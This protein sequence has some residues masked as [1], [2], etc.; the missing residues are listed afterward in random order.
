MFQFRLNGA[1][2]IQISRQ[3]AG[4]LNAIEL[5]AEASLSVP[6]F[7][8][9]AGIFHYRSAK[10]VP[11]TNFK[12]GYNLQQRLQYFRLASLNGGY[13]YLWRESTQ[14]THEYYPVDVSFVKLSTTSVT[15][16]SLLAKSPVL[17]NSFQNQ[18]I[19]GSHY[20]FTYNTQMK[21]DIDVEV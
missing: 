5:G 3:N 16:D 11:Q 10:Y 13:G 2:E 1:Y 18:F 15:F 21:E 4:A 14:K 19:L 20:T 8:T 17:A 12:L 9:P 7:I 6:R